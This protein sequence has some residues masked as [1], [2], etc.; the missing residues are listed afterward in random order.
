[1][2]LAAL[3]F[4]GARALSAGGDDDAGGGQVDV[5]QVVGMP[6]ADAEASLER[7]GLTV[8][9]EQAA[10][11]AAEGTVFEQAPAADQPVDEGAE[12][13]ITV[14]SGSG[15]IAVPDLAGKTQDE[16]IRAITDLGL[17]PG[18]KQTE[19]DTV[20]QGMVIATSP[21]AGT[22]VAPGTA[23]EIQVSST[24]STTAV[25][26]VM[27]QAEAQARA[28]LEGAGFQVTVAQ[29]PSRN[30]ERGMVIAQ[31]PPGGSEVAPNSPVQIIVG[32]GRDGGFPWED[33]EGPF[34][35]N[36]PFDPG[37]LPFDPEDPFGF[38]ED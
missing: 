17:V 15:Q 19:S 14:S 2:V 30:R 4:F 28:T 8:Q 21:P 23:I 7:E 32:S 6:Q 25:P 22:S 3:L 35:P 18:P 16:A 34:D 24:P 36:D 10:S 5:P 12:V 20:E 26:D 38:N 33:G 1:V 9:V 27:G 13:T 31:N 11:D 29:Q 37:D